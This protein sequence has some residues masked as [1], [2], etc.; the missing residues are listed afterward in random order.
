MLEYIS[1]ISAS[2]SA[3][4]ESIENSE[5]SSGGID[6]TSAEEEEEEVDAECKGCEKELVSSVPSC[7]ISME[8]C[9]KTGEEEEDSSSRVSRLTSNSDSSKSSKSSPSSSN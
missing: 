9:S 8:E 5:T 1:S 6:K 3:C 7:N 2:F 4:G